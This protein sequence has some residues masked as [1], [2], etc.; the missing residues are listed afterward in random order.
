MFFAYLPFVAFVIFGVNIPESNKN[1]SLSTGIST[2]GWVSYY[3]ILFY[4][5]Y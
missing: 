5:V 2:T 1:G 3:V 4:I